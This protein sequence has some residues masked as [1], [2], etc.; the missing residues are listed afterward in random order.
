MIQFNIQRFRKL[1]KWTLVNDKKYLVKSFLQVFAILTFLFLFFTWVMNRESVHS[2]I[3]AYETCSIAVIILFGVTC[4]V[5]SSF[6]FYSME[7]KHDMQTLMMLPASNF[8]KYMVRYIHWIFV[9]ILSVAAF[10]VADVLQYTLH[11]VLGHTYG[12]YV[13]PVLV[14]MLGEFISATPASEELRRPRFLLSLFVLVVWFQSLYAVG[15]TLFR[16]RKFNWIITTVFI[17][18]IGMLFYKV[19]DKIDAVQLNDQSDMMDYVIGLG[20]YLGWTIVNYW[21]SY[22]LFCRTQVISKWVNL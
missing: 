14:D 11:L 5:G 10:L 18:L 6:M 9:V 2:S 15:A 13:V 8:E 7:G 3:N 16:T 1:A 19:G 12:M 21:L 22:R 20:F 17:I 4:V